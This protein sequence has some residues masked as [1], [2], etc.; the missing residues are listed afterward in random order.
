MRFG[1]ADVGGSEFWA[2]EDD[3]SWSARAGAVRVVLLGNLSGSWDGYWN[4][5]YGIGVVCR[6]FDLADQTTLHL[7]EKEY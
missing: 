7:K 5:E 6:R 4:L 3:I 1:E 2:G